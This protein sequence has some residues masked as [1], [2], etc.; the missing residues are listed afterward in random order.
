[1]STRN[2]ANDG[3]RTLMSK[4]TIARKSAPWI[5]VG[6]ILGLCCLAGLVAAV[7]YFVLSGG[8][9]GPLVL[10]HDPQN[11]Q[12]IEVGET[13][14]VRAVASD[15]RKI[16]RLE[17]WVDGQLLESET[18]NVRGGIS[19][20]PLLSQWQPASAGAHT[21]SVRAFNIAGIRGHSTINVNVVASADRD[22]DS[23]ADSADIC[24]DQAGI[25]FANGC[26]DQDRDGT[27]DATD[28]CASSAGIPEASGCPS[29]T[30]GDS[31]GD[32]TPDVTD[33]CPGIPGSP[34]SD[35]CPDSDGD[36]VADAEDSCVGE[37]GPV[38]SGGCPTPG[39]T[40]GD[41]I[42]DDVDACPAEWGLPELNG[43]PEAAAVSDDGGAMDGGGADSDSDGA[44]DDLD[45]CPDE[46]GLEEDDYCPPPGDDPEE[47]ED[48]FF[49]FPFDLFFE[50]HF[51]TSVEFEALN[52]EVSRNYEN[53]W[54]Y[55]R[56]AGGDMDLYEFEPDGFHEWNIEEVIGGANSVNLAMFSG[57]PLDVFA[58]CYAMSGFPFPML[59]HLGSITSQHTA[60]VWDGRI[61]EAESS[62]GSPGDSFRVRYHICSPSC[63]ETALPSPVITSHTTIGH[64]IFLNWD[65]EGD[66]STIQGFKLYLNSNLIKDIP[67]INDRSVVWHRSDLMCVEEWEFDLTAYAGPEAGEPDLESS[68]SNSV[69]WEGISCEQNI[70]VTFETLNLHNPPA[71]EGGAHTPGP[72]TGSCAATGGGAMESVVFDAADCAWFP[73]PPGEICIGR[74][75][76]A[77]NHSVQGLLDWI[78]NEID[79][80][81]AWGPCPADNFSASSTDTI[82]IQANPGDDLTAGCFIGD[83]D[84]G[85]PNDVL[86]DGQITVDTS[87]LSPDTTLTQTI[88]G[89]YLDVILKIDLFPFGD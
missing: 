60:E 16:V 43:C 32:G 54:C 39:D 84:V 12:Q 74:K 8:G 19:S 83:L 5:T 76:G 37:P 40:D 80:C 23:V 69:Y 89:D 14:T 24:P 78:H 88:P 72:I 56:L 70:R 55:A 31:D 63:D 25:V 65:W 1:M 77:G 62:G 50:A 34:L 58:D 6:S 82:S 59:H 42:L 53:V 67:D 64:F 4:R 38:E 9:G 7:G 21:I 3:A 30:E 71:D 86:F 2:Y 27:P 66:P 18:T 79:D 57:N 48:L 35:G 75:L 68:P 46:A 87:D 61:I 28:A 73:F 81:P 45:P 17:L 36:L 29:I 49:D 15:E 22:N 10:I 52:F 41:G 85:N 33:A 44:P 51:L 11:G 26:P 13:A 47:E 20:F